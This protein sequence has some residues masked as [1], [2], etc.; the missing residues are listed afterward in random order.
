MGSYAVAEVWPAPGP[1]GPRRRG[2]PAGVATDDPLQSRPA[3][4]GGAAHRLL[5][6]GRSARVGERRGKARELH[7]ESRMSDLSRRGFIGSAAVA[8]AAASATSLAAV[9]EAGAGDVSFQNN[10]PD[11]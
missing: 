3:T 9:R 1:R 2:R 8:A 6:A 4:H 5:R 7:K 10:V 11:E